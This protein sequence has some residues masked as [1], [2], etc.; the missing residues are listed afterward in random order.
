MNA[1]GI[2][3]TLKTKKPGARP[4]FFRVFS[5]FFLLFFKHHADEST[6]IE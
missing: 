1:D 5:V 2:S 6:R 3:G 4:G